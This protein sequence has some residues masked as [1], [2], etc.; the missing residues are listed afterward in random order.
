[1]PVSNNIFSDSS[2]SYS[3]D[4]STSEGRVIAENCDTGDQ[5]SMENRENVT[6][7]E[8]SDLMHVCSIEAPLFASEK[9]FT[10]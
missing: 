5:G 6:E 2:S 1:V 10:N 3:S 7:G 9:A 4:D 8:R